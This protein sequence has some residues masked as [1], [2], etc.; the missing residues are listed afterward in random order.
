ML[1]AAAPAFPHG[2]LSIGALD[3]NFLGHFYLS[4]VE[5]RDA[6]GKALVHLDRM[7]LEYSLMALLLNEVKVDALRLE[8]PK[9]NLSVDESGEMDLL[10][11]FGPSEEAVE[12]DEPVEPFSGLPIDVVLSELAIVGGAVTIE[13][14]AGDTR[15]PSLDFKLGLSV[16]G[17]TVNVS[18]MDLDVDLD[19]PI[20]QPVKLDS[21]FMLSSGNLR[22]SELSMY[23]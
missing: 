9:I 18:G 6:D 11:V 23:I 16:R 13:D 5:I 14:P 3:T 21:S 19:A 4:D 7:V 8:G 22:V 15:I 17:S 20:D 2:E 12:P 10:K 1:T